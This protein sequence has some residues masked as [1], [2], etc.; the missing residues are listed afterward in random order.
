MAI[1]HLMADREDWMLGA[2]LQVVCK[3]LWEMKEWLVAIQKKSAPPLPCPKMPTRQ[4]LM[5]PPNLQR[6]ES[7]VG[8]QGDKV[9]DEADACNTSTLP[10]SKGKR[11]SKVSEVD[12]VE[13]PL[14]GGQWE[15]LGA[16]R[17]GGEI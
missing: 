17:K 9:R 2:E 5:N 13:H 14:A 16:V 8:D 15:G 6:G 10:W 11:G 7:E 1:V 12:Q 4:D 3:D